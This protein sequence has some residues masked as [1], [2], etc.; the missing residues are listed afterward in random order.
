MGAMMNPSL[1]LAAMFIVALGT[2]GTTATAFAQ[3]EEE[4]ETEDSIEIADEA[5][6]AI[7]PPEEDED[8]SEEDVLFHQALCEAEITTEALEELGGCD[9]LPPLVG[10]D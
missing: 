8:V 2:I 7:F 10:V 6:H 4:E 5:L 9:A 3:A 1:K